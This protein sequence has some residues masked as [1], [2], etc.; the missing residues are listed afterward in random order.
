[1]SGDRGAILVTGARGFIGGALLRRLTARGHEVVGVDLH[2]DGGLVHAGDVGRPESFAPLL[3]RASTVVHAAAL[4]TNAL[5]DDAMWRTNVLAT[6]DL[7]AAAARSGVGRFV[8]VS[9]IVVYGNAARGELD[10]EHPVHAHGGSYVTTKLAAEH[11]VLAAHAERGIEVVIV[12]PGDVY[13]PGSRPW[14]V[15]PIGLVRSRQLVLPANGEACFRPV[16][17]D[18]LVRGIEAAALSPAA[19]NRI[20]NLSCEGFVTTREFF[21]FHHRW[22]GR[23]D[24]LCLPTPVAWALAESSFRAKRAFGV[25]SEAS[26]ASVLQLT[27]RAWFS[28]RKAGEVLGWRPEIALADGM[29]DAEAWARAQGL[30]DP[31]R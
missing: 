23:S 15:E 29:R 16:H 10:E 6:R 19:A 11:V 27:S 21:A 4:V 26:G 5:D 31:T 9:S 13:G 18:D 3:E 24:P 1:M 30:L 2:G 20:F 22:L 8:H 17:V 12:R 7:V 25:R 28:I 14:V